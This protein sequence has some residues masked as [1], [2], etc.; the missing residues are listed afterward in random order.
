MTTVAT[1]P[2]AVAQLVEASQAHQKDLTRDESKVM[3]VLE[4]LRWAAEGMA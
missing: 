2:A 3:D 4:F 1:Y